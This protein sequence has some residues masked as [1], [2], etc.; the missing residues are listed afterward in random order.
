MAPRAGE[1]ERRL[2]A[3]RQRRSR[4]RYPVFEFWIRLQWILS[5]RGVRS[6]WIGIAEAT[7]NPELP[8][9]N[10]E[11]ALSGNLDLVNIDRFSIN[12][13]NHGTCANK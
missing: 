6:N 9:L 2:L 11:S 5:K 1:L 3:N 12:A 7:E 10:F 4:S 13:P 8:P